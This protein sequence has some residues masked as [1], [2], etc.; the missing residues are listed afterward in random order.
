MRMLPGAFIDFI[1]SLLTFDLLLL[2][3]LLYCMIR[4]P[5]TRAKMR[6]EGLQRKAVA[7]DE[8]RVLHLQE[9]EGFVTL[10]KDVLLLYAVSRGDRRVATYSIESL[11]GAVRRRGET[12]E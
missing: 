6:L 2:P 9:L 4:H 11:R 10:C 3:Y 12:D 1:I 8:N 7:V 5:L